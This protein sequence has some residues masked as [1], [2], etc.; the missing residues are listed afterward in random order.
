MGSLD[1]GAGWDTASR[2]EIAFGVALFNLG[3]S[4]YKRSLRD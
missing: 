2:V 3:L 4:L 1:G